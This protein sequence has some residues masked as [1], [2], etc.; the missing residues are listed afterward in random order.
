MDSYSVVYPYN[1]IVIDNKKKIKCI[2]I[3]FKSLDTC[4]DMGQPCKHY[5][6][7]KKA[8]TK[9]DIWHNSIYICPEYANLWR[10]KI[11]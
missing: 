1:E 11:D 8:V 4:Y 3:I 9:D 7:W 5:T 2:K 6:I 10:Q